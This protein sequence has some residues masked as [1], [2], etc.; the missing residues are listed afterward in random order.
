MANNVPNLQQWLIS[1]IERNQV[2]HNHKE[3]MAWAATAFYIPAIIALAFN[4]PKTTTCWVLTIVTVLFL[5]GGASVS[6]FV[7][8]QFRNRWR[9][10]DRVWGLIRVLGMLNGVG[11][12]ATANWQ[13]DRDAL[14]PD[15][16]KREIRESGRFREERGQVEI[17]SYIAIGLATIIAAILFWVRSPICG[18]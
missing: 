5:V 15:F 10:A 1:E 16:I 4:M 14:Y 18:G 7:R 3:T 12:P 2:Y 13:M 9:A 8:F 17:V 6:C 11:I